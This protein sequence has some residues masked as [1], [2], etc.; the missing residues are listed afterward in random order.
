MKYR[1][2]IVT[3]LAVATLAAVLLVVN[4][5]TAAQT[6]TAG[7]ATSSTVTGQVQVTAPA[8]GAQPTT[9]AQ[10]PADAP[11]IADP[12]PPPAEGEQSAYAGRTSG[13]EATIAIAVRGG[14][15]SAYICD[16]KETEAWLKGTITDGT[17]TLQGRDD[18][19][20]DGSIQGDA[21]FGTLWIQGKQWPY[22]AQRAERPAGLYQGS[23]TVDGAPARVGWIV[24]PDGS[25]VGVANIGGVARPAPAIDPYQLSGVQV[26]GSTIVPR[27]VDGADN[28]VNPPS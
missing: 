5:R 27:P 25:Q 4:M 2:P 7:Q 21:V 19:H 14:E 28:V 16:G 10:A 13:N 12:P 1:G 22:A 18:A 11:S 17:L 3:L 23:G 8:A 26:G 24:L 20:A 15:V 9:G 6:Q